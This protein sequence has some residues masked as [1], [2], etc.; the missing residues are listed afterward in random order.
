[1]RQT[2]SIVAGLILLVVTNASAAES[3]AAG[4]RGPTTQPAPATRPADWTGAI[5]HAAESHPSDLHAQFQRQLLHVLRDQP[6]LGRNEM[7]GLAPEDRELVSAVIHGL[8]GFRDASRA[9]PSGTTAEKIK[10]LLQMGDQLRDCANLAVNHLTLCKSVERFGV[11]QP[12]PAGTLTAGAQ[13]PVI[14]YFEVV[15]FHPRRG[16]DGIWETNLNYELV[17]YTQTEPSVPVFSKPVMP[18]IDR[19]RSR[20]RDFFL[21]D[22]VT[23]PARLPAGHYLLKVTITDQAA[24][25]IG[26][27]T[28][29]VVFAARH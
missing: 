2:A 5:L 18:V 1:M 19:C 23:F 3:Q 21:A 25:R 11:Y 26:E 8:I 28:L 16:A 29:P 14:V 27:A 6:A 24:H 22:R 4:A 12:L 9:D 17:L 15:N 7:A 10:P 13:T 20:R